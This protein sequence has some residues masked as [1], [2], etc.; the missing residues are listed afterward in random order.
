MQES[1]PR[2]AHLV[3]LIGTQAALAR[4]TGESQHTPHR[5]GDISAACGGRKPLSVSTESAT[6]TTRMVAVALSSADGPT[7]GLTRL[8][9]RDR[10]RAPRWRARHAPPPADTR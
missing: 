5:A 2:L 9:L 3:C 10:C 6:A 1:R 7:H 4:R 8:K